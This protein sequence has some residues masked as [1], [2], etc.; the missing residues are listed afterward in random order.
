MGLVYHHVSMQT[1]SVVVKVLVELLHQ[2]ALVHRKASPVARDR[3]DFLAGFDSLRVLGL[4]EVS[5]VY[6]SIG[7]SL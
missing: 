6:H 7:P 3:L 4:W 2:L 1:P 5:N